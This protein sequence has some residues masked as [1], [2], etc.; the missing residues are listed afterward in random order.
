LGA[1]S[2]AVN[3]SVLDAANKSKLAGDASRATAA[4][5]LFA[6]SQRSR[7][8]GRHEGII[9]V[10]GADILDVPNPVRLKNCGRK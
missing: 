3:V 7:L 5:A 8:A 4:G 2:L 9:A 1:A 6:R 10:C